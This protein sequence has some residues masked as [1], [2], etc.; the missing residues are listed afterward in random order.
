MLGPIAAVTGVPPLSARTPAPTMPA[1]R[2]R[3]PAWRI[4]TAGRLPLVGTRAS[5]IGRQ[6]A[7]SRSIARPG[8]SLQSPSQCSYTGRAVPLPGHRRAV[9]ICIDCS[10]Q[11]GPVLDYAG[12][13]IFCADPE[14][15]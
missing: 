3:Q 4:A 12:G 11:A 8:E 5:A 7:V 2:P 10:A 13:I 15:E 14:V 6:S 9:G 1:S